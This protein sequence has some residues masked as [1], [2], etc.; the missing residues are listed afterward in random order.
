M[1]AIHFHAARHEFSFLRC[2]RL[3][4]GISANQKFATTRQSS[5]H[6][7][8]LIKLIVSQPTPT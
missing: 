6:H 2:E 4:R 5:Y 3:F 7:R 8:S 1:L